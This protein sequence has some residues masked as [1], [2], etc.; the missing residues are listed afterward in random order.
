MAAFETHWVTMWMS[1]ILRIEVTRKV[2]LGHHLYKHTLINKYVYIYTYIAQCFPT[3]ICF[4]V[5]F[6]IRGPFQ[7][8]QYR[9]YPA[10]D[11]SHQHAPQEKILKYHCRINFL[12]HGYWRI[13][14][15]SSRILCSLLRIKCSYEA[16]DICY[17]WTSESVCLLIRFEGSKTLFIAQA[18]MWDQ[19]KDIFVQIYSNNYVLLS[20]AGFILL[21]DFFTTMINLCFGFTIHKSLL[22]VLLLLMMT[23]K[24][25][26]WLI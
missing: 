26:L 24:I 15:H 16:V 13:V 10:A 19:G 22:L 17:I 8:A 7:C 2:N 21:L 9:L 23:I 1:L 25:F 14:Q 3:K 20:W 11:F 6:W 18:G 5:L 12:G 4:S